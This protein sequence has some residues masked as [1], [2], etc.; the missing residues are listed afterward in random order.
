[1]PVLQTPLNYMYGTFYRSDVII[2]GVLWVGFY[3][4]ENS[5]SPIVLVCR[6]TVSHYTVRLQVL[7]Y[8]FREPIIE[9]VESL[10]PIPDIQ[11]LYPDT[12]YLPNQSVFHILSK[13]LVGNLS[14]H[15]PFTGSNIALTPLLE[16]LNMSSTELGPGIEK[17]AQKMVVSLLSIDTRGSDVFHPLFQFA[18]LEAS[19]CTT[20]KSGAVYNYEMQRLVGVYGASAT[21][22]LMMAVVG[23][24][25]LMR[26][27]VC[28]SMTVSALL[29]TT[30][31][32][33]L[34]RLLVGTCLGAV[35]PPMELGELRLKFGEV[36]TGDGFTKEV[37]VGGI[38]HV[39]LGVEGEVFPIRNGARYL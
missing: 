37:G 33:T 3:R 38:G 34:D 19:Q 20:T 2:D 26:N 16:E 30:R 14:T 7:N 36:R 32:P 28:S 31:N 35:P 11:P 27:G 1:M 6:R 17:M 18:A 9:A 24:V 4:D 39:A 13:S 22:A 21:M 23:F 12:R 15:S 29:R 25:A 8:Q 10:G 5:V